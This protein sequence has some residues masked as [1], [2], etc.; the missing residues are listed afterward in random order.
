MVKNIFFSADSNNSAADI[1][2][3]KVYSVFIIFDTV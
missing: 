1:F 2:F 3:Q